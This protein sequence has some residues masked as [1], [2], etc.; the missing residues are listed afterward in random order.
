MYPTLIRI[1]PIAIRTYGVFLAVAFILGLY[2]LKIK[3]RRISVSEQDVDKLFLWILISAI[4]GSR[5]FYVI[6]EWGFYKTYPVNIFRVWEGG[7]HFFGGLTASIA[8]VIFFTLRH[9]SIPLWKFADAAIPSVALGFAIGKVGCFFAGCCHGLPC[10]LPWAVTFN[11]PESLAVQGV[12]LHPSQVYEA[13]AN[14]LVFLTLEKLYKIKGRDGTLFWFGIFL[15]SFVRFHL[16]FFRWEKK[17]F[18]GLTFYQLV[19]FVFVALSL[20]FLILLSLKKDE[21]KRVEG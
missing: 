7:L 18:A 21:K 13:V 9:S 11:N 5:L 4:V 6:S 10:H 15:L 20:L 14:F 3:A 12:A 8:A 17:F 2:L 16:E 1:G 19:S